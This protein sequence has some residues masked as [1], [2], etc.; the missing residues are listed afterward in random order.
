MIITTTQLQEIIAAGASLVIDGAPMTISQLKDMATE[1]SKSKVTI[2]IKN[3][4][5][6]THEHL[7]LIAS[8]APG[9]IVFDLT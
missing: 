4:Q 6:I 9:K 8:L 2:T 3:V 7:K 5:N 1:A